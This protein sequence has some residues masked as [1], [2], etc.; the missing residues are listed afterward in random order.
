MDNPWQLCQTIDPLTFHSQET[1]VF[2]HISVKNGQVFVL[3]KASESWEC[4]L[5]N[6][7]APVSL[8][9][10]PAPLLENLQ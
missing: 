3:L 10:H 1:N 7:G 8:L 4:P 9:H 6:R 2:G 5:S